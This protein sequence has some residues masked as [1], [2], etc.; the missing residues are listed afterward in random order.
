MLFKRRPR[1][2]LQTVYK[3]KIIIY[4]DFT[5]CI[6]FLKAFV[7]SAETSNGIIERDI[8]LRQG[9][10]CTTS[11]CIKIGYYRMMLTI[12]FVLYQKN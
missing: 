10:Q 1:I 6:P 2:K 8:V 12:T 5:Y 3:F 9:M 7:H 11:Y 4:Y